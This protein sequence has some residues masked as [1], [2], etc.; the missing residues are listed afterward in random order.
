MLL[1]AA[2]KAIHTLDIIRVSQ[3]HTQKLKM[4]SA[5]AEDL[6]ISGLKIKSRSYM[7]TFL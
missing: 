7:C 2:G 6:E 5:A 3:S 1:E 4:L